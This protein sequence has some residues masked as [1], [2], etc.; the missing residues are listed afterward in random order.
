MADYNDTVALG[1]KPPDP[2]AQFSTLNNILGFQQKNLDIQA[3]KQ[4]LQGQAAEVQQE[5]Q[6]ASQRQAA[7]QFYKN[8]DPTDHI[9]QDGT[10]DLNTAMRDPALNATGDAKPK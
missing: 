10:L 5:Q 3:K 9:G 1:V 4:A 2:N 8:F 6:N 7:A